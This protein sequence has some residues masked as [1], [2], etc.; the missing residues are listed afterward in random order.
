MMRVLFASALIAISLT[1]PAMAQDHVFP[2]DAKLL[3][4][5]RLRV[6]DGRATGL[7][8]GVIEG[9]GST[10]IVA[11]GDPGEG[12][13]PLGPDT[14]F[15]IGSITKVFTTTILADMVLKNEVTL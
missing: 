10:R 4:L 6:D 5:I 3:E 14:V 2:D 8:L 15:E 13:P 7:V 1:A 9:D 12:A 11:Y